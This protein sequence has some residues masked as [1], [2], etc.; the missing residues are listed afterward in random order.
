MSFLRID[1][2][3]ATV[4]FFTEDTEQLPLHL[5]E[6]TEGKKYYKVVTLIFSDTGEVR[7]VGAISALTFKEKTL[8]KKEL[9]LMGYTK[10]AYNH[11]SKPHTILL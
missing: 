10:I 2:H 8:L 7:I 4:R 1:P 9:R 5:M 6:T 11:N 3:S